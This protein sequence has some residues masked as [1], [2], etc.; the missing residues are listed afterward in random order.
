MT[1]RVEIEVTPE[2]EAIVI[3]I[4]GIMHLWIDR[5]KLLGVQSWVK[6]G[7]RQ[8]FIEFAMESGCITSDYDTREKW[9][10]ILSQLQSVLLTGKIMLA[11]GETESKEG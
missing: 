5:T 6:T 11:D 3:R 8:F 1:E 9:E 7:R 4:G 10:A 2:F